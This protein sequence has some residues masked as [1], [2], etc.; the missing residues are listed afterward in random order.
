M[1][2]CSIPMVWQFIHQDQRYQLWQIKAGKCFLTKNLS[3]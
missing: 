1:H 2:Y 3:H